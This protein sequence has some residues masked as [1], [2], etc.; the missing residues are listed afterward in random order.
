MNWFKNSTPYVKRVN[1]IKTGAVLLTVL[2]WSVVFFKIFDERQFAIETGRAEL[3]NVAIGLKLHAQASLKASDEILR[4]LKFHYET[5][6]LKDLGLVKRYFQQDALGIKFLNQVG[7]IDEHGIYTFSSLPTHK[8]VDLSDRE[9]FKT[10]KAGYAYPIFISKPVL[11]RATGKWSFQLTR[12]LN[13]SDGSFNGVATAS[14]NPI[15]FLE[16]FKGI[17]LGA[18]SVIGLVGMDGYARTMRVG[19]TNRVDDTLKDLNLPMEVSQHQS[20]YFFSDSFFD[21]TKRMYVFQRLAD[22][23]LFVI[24]GIKEDVAFVNYERQRNTYLACAFFL[25][26]LIALLVWFQLGC[27]Q[28]SQERDSELARYK[29]MDSESTQIKSDLENK[30]N[31]TQSMANAG[32]LAINS[33][34][35]LKE[36]LNGLTFKLNSLEKDADIFE[37]VI[38]TLVRLQ[39]GQI[40][41]DEFFSITK[42]LCP[43]DV[44]DNIRLNLSHAEQNLEEINLFIDLLKNASKH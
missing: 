25:T 7:I 3:Q 40:T 18:D 4:V 20:G 19:N 28:R 35:Q 30:L 43:E 38:Q 31:S 16:H 5:T 36:S 42:K 13:K 17:Q 39:M 23:P 34:N 10:H 41:M 29:E 32:Q 27:M 37:S 24:V 44:L 21:H 8:R 14:L 9:H 26:A 6:G 33:T 22:M 1:A 15:D 2:V 12:R 11:G